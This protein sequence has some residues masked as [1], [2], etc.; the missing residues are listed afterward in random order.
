M[1][2]LHTN[3]NE[4]IKAIDP[5]NKLCLTDKCKGLLD[6]WKSSTDDPQWEEVI[7]VLRNIS[8]GSW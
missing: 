3:N 2:L 5:E 4:D 6:F 1:K 8:Q 7:L